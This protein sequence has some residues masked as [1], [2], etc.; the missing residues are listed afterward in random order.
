MLFLLFQKVLLG[1]DDRAGPANSEPGDDFGSRKLVMFHDVASDEGTGASEASLAVHSHSA[2]TLFGQVEKLFDYRVTG[3]A[4]VH[5]EEVVVLEARFHKSSR[6]VDFFVETNDAS[7]VVLAE[8]G[9]VGFWCVQWVA[10]F[11]KSNRK[12]IVKFWVF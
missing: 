3:R 10:F 7:D 12:L 4:A 2:R 5:V 1:S 9:D 11:K 6:V 8:V